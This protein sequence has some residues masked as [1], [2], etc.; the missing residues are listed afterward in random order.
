MGA[1]ASAPTGKRAVGCDLAMREDAPR[2][3]RVGATVQDDR[4]AVSASEHIGAPEHKV[5]APE[6]K[7][8]LVL[9]S[10]RLH[11]VSTRLH[12]VRA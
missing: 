6:H 4:M 11:R 8:N 9:Q 1:V 12:R 2:R 5:G 10:T 7:V 3:S